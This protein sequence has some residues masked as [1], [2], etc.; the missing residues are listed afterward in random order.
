MGHGGG[1]LLEDTKTDTSGYA[2]FCRKA[3]GEVNAT[4]GR[5]F[6]CRLPARCSS[7]P[8]LQQLQAVLSFLT[9]RFTSLGS[10]SLN[11]FYYF[12]L[13]EIL[14]ISCLPFACL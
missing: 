5:E 2:E 11:D 13:V 6:G 4:T 3:G 9:I 1:G 7:R 12:L 10:V 8:R 14:L